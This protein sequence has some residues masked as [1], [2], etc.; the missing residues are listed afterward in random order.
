M[1]LPTDPNYPEF[2]IFWFPLVAPFFLAALGV[3]GDLIGAQ[4]S[5]K[6]AVEATWE[7]AFSILKNINLAYVSIDI[8]ALAEFTT[9]AAGSRL[10]GWQVWAY[11][12]AAMIGLLFHMSS[13]LMA[14]LLGP[15]TLG[16]LLG[17]MLACV[18]MIGIVLIRVTVFRRIE[19]IELNRLLKK[20]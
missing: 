14:A 4:I 7:I 11:V 18:G 6:S 2:P 8:W 1:K 10:A 9:A 16:L 5:T 17:L 19:V 13:Y 3:F 12:L 15:S 20:A